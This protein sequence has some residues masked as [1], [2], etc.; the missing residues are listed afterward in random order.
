[1]CAASKCNKAHQQCKRTQQAGVSLAADTELQQITRMTPSPA[2]LA[3]AGALA[4]MCY[5]LLVGDTLTYQDQ[6]F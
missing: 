3:Q 5:L 6:R 2:V 1:M 4:M